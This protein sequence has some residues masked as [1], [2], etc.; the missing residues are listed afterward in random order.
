MTATNHIDLS[1]RVINNFARSH[2]LGPEVLSLDSGVI[3]E[4]IDAIPDTNPELVMAL[5]DLLRREGVCII[6]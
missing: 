3:E 6:H 2:E 5:E 4:L 1:E